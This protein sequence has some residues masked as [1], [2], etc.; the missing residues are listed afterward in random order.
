MENGNDK[1]TLAEITMMILSLGVIL[2]G[3]ILGGVFAYEL[4]KPSF[5]TQDE[6]NEY[7]EIANDVYS[8]QLA[9]EL[10]ENQRKNILIESQEIGKIK[11]TSV[12]RNKGFIVFDFNANLVVI[13]QY[14]TQLIFEILIG[15]ILGM[16]VAIAFIAMI[17]YLIFII[18]IIKEIIS[19]IK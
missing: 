14:K 2:L 12:E 9:G 18:K 1:Y 6:I 10:I 17:V 5:F 15:I 16:L 3:L 13:S 19:S 4:D 7:I 11:L 8:K